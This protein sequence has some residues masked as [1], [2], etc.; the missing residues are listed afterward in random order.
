MNTAPLASTL[1]VLAF[2]SGS[3][4]FPQRHCRRA[5]SPLITETTLTAPHVR[6]IDTS[7]ATFASPRRAPVLHAR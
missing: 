5:K 7:T 6:R 2:V 4:G 3:V 1:A